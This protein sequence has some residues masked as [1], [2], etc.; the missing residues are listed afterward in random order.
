MIIQIASDLHL[1]HQESDKVEEYIVPKG[2][3]LVLA[4]DIGNLHRYDQLF[5]FLQK[6]SELFQYV[7]YVPGN[8]EYYRVNNRKML[9][10]FEAYISC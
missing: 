4:G 5:T 1:N 8:H 9:T 7:L 2:D 3:V 10:M 6:V